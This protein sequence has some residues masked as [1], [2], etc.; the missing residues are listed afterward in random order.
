V[1]KEAKPVRP[2]TATILIYIGYAIGSLQILA[3]KDKYGVLGVLLGVSILLI[4]V[5]G[6]ANSR[7]GRKPSKAIPRRS[8]VARNRKAAKSRMKIVGGK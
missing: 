6:V 5:A 1:Y 8:S 4:I 3:F 2:A 7:Q